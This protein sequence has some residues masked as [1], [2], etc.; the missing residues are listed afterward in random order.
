MHLQF[1]K[2]PLT[3]PL[4]Q[5]LKKIYLN[6]NER[7]NG[8]VDDLE[9][10]SFKKCMVITVFV[11]LSLSYIMPD[12]GMTGPQGQEEPATAP[13]QSEQ[14]GTQRP[15]PLFSGQGHYTSLQLPC[16]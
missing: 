6:A 10:A 8:Y 15:A 14:E 11:V 4:S 16:W 7:E 12:L 13:A 1:A 3:S 5:P 2:L 9:T